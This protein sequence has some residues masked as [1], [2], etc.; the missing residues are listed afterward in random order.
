[1]KLGDFGIA[2]QLSCTAACARTQIG[3]PYYLS[4]ELCQEKPYSWSSDIWA[5]GCILYELCMLKVPFDASNIS[6]LVQKICRGPTPVISGYSDFVKG[7]C[8]EM[9]SRS[10]GGRPSAESVLQRPRMQA[11]VKQLLDEAQQAQAEGNATGGSGD[12]DSVDERKSSEA[13]MQAPFAEAKGAYIS[14]AGNYKKNDLVDYHSATHKDWLPATVTNVDS[15]RRIVIDL[16]PNTWLSCEQQGQS[17]RPRKSTAQPVGFAG[18]ATPLRHRSPSVGAQI[19]SGRGGTPG[20]G[21][22]RSPTPINVGNAPAREFTPSHVRENSPSHRHGAVGYQA[23][24]NGNRA[25][26]PSLLRNRQPSLERLAREA[27]SRIDSRFERLET[28][29]RS[30]AGS[31]GSTPSRAS[32]RGANGPPPFGHHRE[33]PP[34]MPRVPGSPLHRNSPAISAGMAIAGV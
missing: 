1:L 8:T 2:K 28:D 5:M 20:R 31:R 22:D 17:V 12:I 10:P 7:L 15:E 3:T 19:G 9:L 16:K 23:G 13:A 25:P 33:P 26:S 4:P 14:F 21:R 11:I 6:G 27:R 29:S 24:G 34:G 30:G 32:P 18:V